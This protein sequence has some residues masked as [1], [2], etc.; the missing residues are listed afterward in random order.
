MTEFYIRSSGK[1]LPECKSCHRPIVVGQNRVRRFLKL[2]GI[3]V[4]DYD[5]MLKKQ[6]GVCL[7][8][9][10]PEKN[11]KLA[12]DHDHETGAVRG[13]LCTSCNN[14]LGWFE[15]YL[16]SIMKYL[17]LYFDAPEQIERDSA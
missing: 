5:R 12:V 7:I 15:R 8:C 4:Q 16:P 3:T 10:R 17:K 11:R 14:T 9:K 2:Y 1:P 13:L 6:D